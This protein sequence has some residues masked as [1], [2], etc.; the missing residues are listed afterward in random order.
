MLVAMFYDQVVAALPGRPGDLENLTPRFEK[1]FVHW[2]DGGGL[3][4]P[5]HDLAARRQVDSS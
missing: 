5:R 4:S 3:E 2:H 1:A